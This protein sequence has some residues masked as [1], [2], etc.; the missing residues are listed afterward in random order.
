MCISLSPTFHCFAF[1]FISVDSQ[2]KCSCVWVHCMTS[3]TEA[4]TE[5]I[6]LKCQ[7]SLKGWHSS[8]MAK[9]CL[10]SSSLF[11]SCT[12]DRFTWKIS[13]LNPSTGLLFLYCSSALGPDG[14]TKELNLGKFRSCTTQSKPVMHWVSLL[15][16]FIYYLCSVFS[17]NI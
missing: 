11:V 8:K 7:M 14:F 1:S 2:P 5:L 9:G 6:A 10:I 3:H 15:L 17:E 4:Y 12:Q 16:S 13:S